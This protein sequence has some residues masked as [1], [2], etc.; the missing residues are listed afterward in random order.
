MQGDRYALLSHEQVAMLLA[1]VRYMPRR[2][3]EHDTYTCLLHIKGIVRGTDHIMVM[4][5]ILA[6]ACA[7][8]KKAKCMEMEELHT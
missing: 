4:L 2:C 1:H 8:P 3:I 6:L 7:A 5:N